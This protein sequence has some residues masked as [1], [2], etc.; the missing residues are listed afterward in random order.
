MLEA[1]QSNLENLKLFK[2][3]QNDFENLKLFKI[4]LE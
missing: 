1:I 4:S 3:I 2:I